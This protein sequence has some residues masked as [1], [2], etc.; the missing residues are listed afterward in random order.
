MLSQIPIAERGVLEKKET[1]DTL[2]RT[3]TENTVGIEI[4]DAYAA[5]YELRKRLRRAKTPLGF[6]VA[7]IGGSVGSIPSRVWPAPEE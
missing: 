7:S 1:W 5:V 3:M 4:P 2:A 6:D